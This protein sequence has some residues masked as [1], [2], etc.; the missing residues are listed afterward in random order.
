MNGVAYE[1]NVPY[2][3]ISRERYERRVVIELADIPGG[4]AGCSRRATTRTSA[5]AAGRRRGRGSASTC[6]ACARRTASTRR[7]SR[8]CAA[9]GCRCGCRR[10]GS[11]ASGR[12]LVGDA[13]GLLDPVSGDGM[14]ECFYSARLATAAILDLLAGRATTLE[15]Y[16]AAV[17]AALVAAAPGLVEAE[18]GARPLAARLVARRPHGALLAE[19]RGHAP[20]RARPSRRAAR[21]RARADARAR[22]SSAARPSRRNAARCSAQDIAPSCRLRWR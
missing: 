14:Y 21:P 8:T 4:Y 3:T 11:R 10:R 6:G 12:S 13:G 20:G 22:A 7:R 17:D 18:E 5:S 15:P 9:T 19:H 2:P 16:E 1:G